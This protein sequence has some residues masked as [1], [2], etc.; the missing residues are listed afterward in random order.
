MIRIA[1]L[2]ATGFIG[3]NLISH[4]KSIPN[5]YLVLYGR[6]A[7]KMKQYESLPNSKLVIGDFTKGEKLDE[8]TK[9]CNLVYHLISTTIP[10]K[11]WNLPEIEI[12][13]NLLPTIKLLNCCVANNVS[14]VIFASSGGT[15]YGKSNKKLNENVKILPF[16]PY[17]ITKATI[18]FYL[19]YF[20]EKSNLNY[21]IYRISNPYGPGLDKLDF[22]VINTWVKKA[23]NNEE[24]HVYGDG[25]VVKDFIYIDDVVRLLAHSTD[26]S[27]FESNLYNLCAEENKSLNDIIEHIKIN[28]NK[29]LRVVYNETKLSDN[30]RVNLD[31][32]RLLS[33]ISAFS[34]TSFNE[35]IKRTIDSYI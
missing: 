20:R 24:I 1:I 33:R 12:Y 11:S 31:N 15:V 3:R 18:E 9:D 10:S 27:V 23:I 25:N 30:T 17:G 2:G 13:E 6:N 5:I 16:S 4:F 8:T 35:G 28:L 29:E 21:D 34:F 7:A 19:E 14:K 22:G 32:S 26:S